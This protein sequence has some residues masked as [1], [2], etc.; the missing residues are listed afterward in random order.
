MEKTVKQNYSFIF[1]YLT[2]SMLIYY[3][4]LLANLI[5]LM[6]RIILGGAIKCTII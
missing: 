3:L 5:T 1:A 4:F 2:M 6:E